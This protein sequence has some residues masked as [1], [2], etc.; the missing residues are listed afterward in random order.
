MT[1]TWGELLG[2]EPDESEEQRRG[3]FRRLRGGLG[4]T[5]RALV[6]SIAAIGFDPTDDESWERLEEALIAGDVGMPSTLELVRRLEK[7]G[8]IETP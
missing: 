1:R 3:V 8:R 7:R 2:D 5:R 6:D 4:K